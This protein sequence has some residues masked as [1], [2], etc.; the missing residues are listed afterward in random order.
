MVRAKK[1]AEEVEELVADEETL[2]AARQDSV[3]L[4]AEE[5]LQEA[6]QPK[7]PQEPEDQEPDLETPYAELQK[8]LDEQKRAFDGLLADKKAALDRAQQAE[9]QLQMVRQMPQ[10]QVAQPQTAAEQGSQFSDD[11]ML[12]YGQARQLLNPYI[13]NFN[14]QLQVYQREIQNNAVRA[15][16][17]DFE[18]VVRE[19]LIPHLNSRPDGGSLAQQLQVAGA[20]AV[21]DYA[22]L[23]KRATQAQ[24]TQPTTQQPQQ[25]PPQAQQRVSNQAAAQPAVP[26]LPSVH[27]GGPAELTP[28]MVDQTARLLAQ[29]RLSD[30]QMMDLLP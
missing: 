28:A 8:Q 22:V 19:H 27:T 21:Y 9:L 18:Q 6:Q 3:T 2:E 23:V 13:Q 11:D 1:S 26:L 7:E 4:G 29:D 17:P 15:Q 10:Q 24:T 30:A 16:H 20:Q 12:T 14:A 5:E 25:P